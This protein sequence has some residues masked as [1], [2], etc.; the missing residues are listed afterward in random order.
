MSADERPTLSRLPAQRDLVA[1]YHPGIGI[2]HPQGAG[3]IPRPEWERPGMELRERYYPQE[4]RHLWE[5]PSLNPLGEVQRVLVDS[6]QHVT[7]DLLSILGRPLDVSAVPAVDPRDVPVD[8]SA[9]SAMPQL[10]VDPRDVPV[11]VPAVP[12]P[13]PDV[14]EE[15]IV[16]P[17]F[18][19]MGVVSID[20]PSEAREASEELIETLSRSEDGHQRWLRDTSRVW[21]LRYFTERMRAYPKQPLVIEPIILNRLARELLYGKIDDNMELPRPLIRKLELKYPPGTAASRVVLEMAWRMKA[22]CLALPEALV[23][24]QLCRIRYNC[25]LQ[26]SRPD[27]GTVRMH[28]KSLE[29]YGNY[30]MRYSRMPGEP[31]G[32]WPDL[33]EPRTSGSL[34]GMQAR[35]PLMEM[36]Y[37]QAKAAFLLL[38]QRLKQEARAELSSN[39][40]RYFISVDTTPIAT[41]M[42]ELQVYRDEESDVLRELFSSSKFREQLE[43]YQWM[44]SRRFLW[45]YCAKTVMHL[46]YVYRRKENEEH[47]GIPMERDSTF[48][49]TEGKLDYGKLLRL[50]EDVYDPKDAI[51]SYYYPGYQGASL[52]TTSWNEACF[53]LLFTV[54]HRNDKG[55]QW[56][57]VL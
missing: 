6:P 35:Y 40:H 56:G 19:E 14:A 36:P 12:Q 55:E 30:L 4:T 10:T 44:K 3:D 49:D 37:Q 32:D 21:N 27:R 28:E 38:Q 20:A 9:V 50:I 41:T 46:I 33:A 57:V 34:E 13:Q 15:T 29:R 23:V 31:E 5:V 39:P 1:S 18:I 53:D 42:G 24:E 47:R 8:V 43:V 11:D 52:E 45:I 16:D 26:L 51:S 22:G 54:I 48:F 2:I 25:I 17:R 7:A